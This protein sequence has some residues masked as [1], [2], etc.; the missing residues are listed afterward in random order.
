VDQ[1]KKQGLEKT[2]AA[3]GLHVVTTDYIGKDGVI[4]GLSDA[5][6]LL[7]QAFAT[8]KGAAPASVSS[9][10][11]FAI[12]QV[13]DVKAAH[14][15]DFA[16]YKSHILDDYRNE[17]VPALLA[18]V[19]N[20]LAD[21]AKALG[22]LKK[23]AAEMN[24]PVKSSDLVG[25]DA[26][27]PDLGAMSGPGAVAFTLAKGAIS[28]PIDAGQTGVVLTVTDKEEPSADDMAKNFDATREQLLNEQRDEIF[29]VFLGTL[30][31]KYEQGGG[32][33][34]SKQAAAPTGIPGA[35]TP[36]S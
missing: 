2:A 31:Q 5:A 26:Q 21:R 19:T 10:D 30:S 24:V 28:G 7:T 17:K 8:D 6:P 33:R 18:G 32:I 12:F 27:V 9:G 23:A 3:H 13:L 22:D 4:G 15:P 16:S 34:Y 20:K 35:P 1:A 29:R 25:Q 36:G 11:G 14:A